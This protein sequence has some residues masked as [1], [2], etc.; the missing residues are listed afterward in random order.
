ML[1]AMLK[2]RLTVPTDTLAARATS[3]IVGF[4]IG[5]YT[6]MTWSNKKKSEFR[7]YFIEL[8]MPASKVLDHRKYH[9]LL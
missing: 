7:R 4:T 6:R 3:L 5:N 1:G 8:L 9:N 2:A